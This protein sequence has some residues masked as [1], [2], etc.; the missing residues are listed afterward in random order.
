MAGPELSSL[1][2]IAVS[3]MTGDNSKIPK[4]AQAR[5]MPRFTRSSALDNGARFRSI[6]RSCSL[7]V[8]TWLVSDLNPSVRHQG[9][10]S[11]RK[12]LYGT[13]G[14]NQFDHRTRA[15]PAISADSYAQRTPGNDSLHHLSIR[16]AAIRK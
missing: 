5:S 12:L 1:I 10:N 15:E 4:P 16:R 6:A 7:G 11:D 14:Q 2:A 9:V 8:G 3:I 13:R